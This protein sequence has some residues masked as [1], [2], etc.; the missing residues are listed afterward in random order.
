[1]LINIG[2][3]WI[4]FGKL[5]Y[6]VLVSWHIQSKHLQRNVLSRVEIGKGQ[7]ERVSY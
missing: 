1:M 4:Y 7:K 3:F 6:L 2:D 5:P